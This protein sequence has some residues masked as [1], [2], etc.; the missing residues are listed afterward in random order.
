MPHACLE[1]ARPPG[2]T[3]ARSL[4]RRA[5]PPPQADCSARPW[6]GRSSRRS[7][8]RRAASTRRSSPRGCGRRGRRAAAATAAGASATR[9]NCSTTTT[10]LPSAPRRARASP[11]C[12]RARSRRAPRRACVTRACAFCSI[13]LFLSLSRARGG[14]RAQ[15]HDLI[16]RAGSFATV[17]LNESPAAARARASRGVGARDDECGAPPPPP[18]SPPS[19]PTHAHAMDTERRSAGCFA[20]MCR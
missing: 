10:T 11:R 9:S 6:R 8:A 15:Q 12:T 19:P 20:I 1:A 4:S 5:P 16:A 7:R 13:T 18:S 3:R 2:L 17:H 14:P